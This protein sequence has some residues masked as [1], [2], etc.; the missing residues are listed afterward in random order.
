MATAVA[1]GVPALVREGLSWR[2]M[3]AS[4]LHATPVPDLRGPGRSRPAEA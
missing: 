2:D 4:A 1:L 3:R